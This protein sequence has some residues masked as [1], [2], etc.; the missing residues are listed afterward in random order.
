M[1]Q[2]QQMPPEERFTRTFIGIVL[3]LSAF[4]SWGKWAALILGVLFLLSAWQGVC[5]MCEIYKKLAKKK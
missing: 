3:V 4:I 2:R 1:G 5:F